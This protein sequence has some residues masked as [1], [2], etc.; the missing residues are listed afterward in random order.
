[1]LFKKYYIL[2]CFLKEIL[3][4]EIFLDKNIIYRN[5]FKNKYYILKYFQIEY[6]MLKY[7]SKQVLTVKI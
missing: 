2:K 4:I 7:F 3:C 6:H 1:M 5:G